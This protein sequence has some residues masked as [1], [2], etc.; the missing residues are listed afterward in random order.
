MNYLFLI[1]NIQFNI[2]NHKFDNLKQAIKNTSTSEGVRGFFNGWKTGVMTSPIFYSIYFPVYEL[3]KQ[4]YSK[5]IYDKKDNFNSIIYTLSASTAAI[6]SNLVTTP[7]WVVRVRYQTEFMY[8][9]RNLKE[10]FNVMKSISSIYKNEGFF[11]LYR[12]FLTEVIGTPQ[13]I[14]QF[15]LYEYLTKIF[16]EYSKTDVIDY[17]YVLVA[18][19]VSKSK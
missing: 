10:N 18:S 6:C 15:N 16:R 19:I 7:M 9:Q 1:L 14:I 4:Q 5:I 11:A 17:K 12:G 8:S 3:S 13:V 2:S